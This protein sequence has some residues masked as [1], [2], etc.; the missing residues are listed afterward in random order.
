MNNGIS[1]ADDGFA[2]EFHRHAGD[3]TYRFER[4]GER[5]GRTSWRRTDLDLDLYWSDGSGWTVRDAAG[6]LLS[7]PWDIEKEAQGPLPPTGVWVSRK[8]PKSYVYDLLQVPA[9]RSA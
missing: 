4:T 1:V 7:R 9:A 8:G 5:N 2:I 3:L 6:T